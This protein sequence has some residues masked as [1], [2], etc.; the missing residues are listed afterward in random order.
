[1]HVSWQNLSILPGK[2][3]P[4]ISGREWRRRA[5][6]HGRSAGAGRSASKAASPTGTPLWP[7]IMVAQLPRWLGNKVADL[8]EP[9][10]DLPPMFVPLQEL[11]NLVCSTWYVNVLAAYPERRN[12]GHGGRLLHIAELLAADLR[13]KGMSVI[14]SN[15]NHG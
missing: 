2:A 15:A 13:L 9:I 12:L 3:C 7:M 14:V 1:M 10:D 11:E 4:T 5:S 6:P 8:P